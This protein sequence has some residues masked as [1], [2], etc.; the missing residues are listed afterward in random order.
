[1]PETE[2]NI[3]NL[4]LCGTFAIVCAV[5]NT[6]LTLSLLE[7]TDSKL[8]AI[9]ASLVLLVPLVEE[10]AK[11]IA[12]YRGTPWMFLLVFCMIESSFLGAGNGLGGLMLRVLPCLM[13]T[14]T[15]MIQYGT[16]RISLEKRSPMI[17]VFGFWAA[18]AIHAGYNGLVLWAMK[19]WLM[20]I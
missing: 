8:S 13:H 15:M 10:G 12:V 7:I 9:T 19:S 17:S 14:V 18:F 3:E 4:F 6:I 20:Q 1:M 5:L 2:K 16:H 11:R